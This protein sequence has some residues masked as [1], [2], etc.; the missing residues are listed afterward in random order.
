MEQTRDKLIEILSLAKQLVAR[1]EEALG[2]AKAPVF[3]AAAQKLVEKGLCLVCKKPRDGTQ[4]RR[5]CHIACHQK[6]VRRMKNSG[7]TEF[8]MIELGKMAPRSSVKATDA[9]ADRFFSDDE[10]GVL[11]DPVVVLEAQQNNKTARAALD[12]KRSAKKPKGD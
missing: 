12:A 2:D 7:K 3:P 6:I 1:C 10:Y 9:T 4:W 8:E 5:G 11:A